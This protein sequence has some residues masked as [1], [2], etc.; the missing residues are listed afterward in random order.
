MRCLHCRADTARVVRR[1][2]AY[3]TYVCSKCARKFV[4]TEIYGTSYHASAR[5]LFAAVEGELR[6]R[7]T[8]AARIVLR[9]KGYIK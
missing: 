8:E 5:L 1:N 4:S 9:E 6:G 2:D 3:R 7:K